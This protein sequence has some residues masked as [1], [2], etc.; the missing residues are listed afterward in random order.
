MSAPVPRGK[1]AARKSEPL[2]TPTPV[3]TADDRVRKEEAMAKKGCPN[4]GS[5]E[6]WFLVTPEL[7]RCPNWAI[8]SLSAALASLAGSAKVKFSKLMRP[9]SHRRFGLSPISTEKV[10]SVSQR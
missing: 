1:A 2:S 5:Q 4:C 8:R 7:A 3:E 6:E 10:E 9:V